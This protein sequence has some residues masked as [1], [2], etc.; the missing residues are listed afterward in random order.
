MKKLRVIVA[1]F[2][3][4]FAAATLLGCF[5]GDVSVINSLNKSNNAEKKDYRYKIYLIT[6]DQGSNYWQLI[7]A[8][9]KKAVEE[10]GDIDYKWIAPKTHDPSEQ[11]ECVKQA[12]KDG[13]KA[14]IISCVSSTEVNSYLEK[15]KESGVKL[16]YV[17]SAATVEAVATLETDSEK[18]GRA[19]GEAMQ[20]ALKAKGVNGG[21]IGVTAGSHAENAEA[22]VKGFQAAFEGSAYVLTEPIYMLGDRQKIRNF[23]KN[24]PNYVGFVGLNSQ[25]T[26]AIGDA[27]KETGK[28]PVFIAFDTADVTLMML[29][30]G[31]VTATMQQN[32]QKMGY[33]A[34][35]LAS[36]ALDGFYNESGEAIDT[37]IGII[38]R[39]EM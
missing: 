25:T 30:D 12:V 6:M 31:I 21:I 39:N 23:V 38:K 20:Q 18:A 5:G 37:G 19:A 17:D 4:F 28:R 14:I 34:V 35:K 13:A 10:L 27:L 15:A 29:K 8:G 1:L 24:N 2:G 32:P 26:F 33:E 16:F 3:C 7:D 9:C 11:G 36:D 22:R